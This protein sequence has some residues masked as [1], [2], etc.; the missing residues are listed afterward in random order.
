MIN[1]LNFLPTKEN[2]RFKVRSAQFNDLVDKL[3]VLFPSAL[4]SGSKLAVVPVAAP[5]SI[6]GPG[7]I[8]ITELKT[9]I[10]TTGAD[11]FTL[12]N[13]SVV[14]TVKKIKLIVTAGDATLTPTSLSGGTTITFSV[15]GDEVTLI[16]NGS[17]WVV[18]DDSSVLGTGATPVVA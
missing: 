10:T 14:G 11:A 9:E 2:G 4:A 1:K 6:S 8:T 3:N 12:A 13:A 17:A 15:V 5:Q 7:A 18:V 16:W